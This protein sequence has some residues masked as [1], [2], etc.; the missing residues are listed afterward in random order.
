MGHKRLSYDYVHHTGG[1]KTYQDQG[2][3]P[4]LGELVVKQT[5]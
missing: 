5:K 4:N 2:A 1:G 3:M